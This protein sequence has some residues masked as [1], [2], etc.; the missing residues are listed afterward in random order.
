MADKDQLIVSKQTANTP[1]IQTGTEALADNPARAGFRIQNIGSL[2][3]F[4]MLGSGASTTVFHVILTGGTANSDGLG[5]NSSY[6]QFGPT[7]YT[8]VVTVQTTSGSRKYTTIE[9]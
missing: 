7:V 9:L 2:P 5:I 8:G 6:E 1:S 3:L 4:V